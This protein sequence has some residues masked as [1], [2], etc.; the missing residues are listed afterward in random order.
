VE[1]YIASKAGLSLDAF[2]D[3]Y[4]RDIRIPALEYWAKDGKLIYRWTNCIENFAVPV[5]IWIDGK[6]T[7]IAPMTE[8]QELGLSTTTA[9]IVVDPDYYV[10][11]FNLYGG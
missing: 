11:S 9:D 1:E 8:F 4:L 3:Q 5:D 10:Y 6:K 7:R 2:F